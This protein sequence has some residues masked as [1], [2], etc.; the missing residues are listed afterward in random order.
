M[1]GSDLERGV[2][3]PEEVRQDLQDGQDKKPKIPGF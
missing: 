3:K 2:F 1:G